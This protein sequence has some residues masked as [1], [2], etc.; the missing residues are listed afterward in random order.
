L[1]GGTETPSN[2]STVRRN[3]GAGV[4][5]P[6]QDEW[7]KAAYYDAS[8][9]TYYDYPTESDTPPDCTSPKATPNSANCGNSTIRGVTVVGA[10]TGSPSPYGTFDQGGNVSESNENIVFGGG[11]ANRGGGWT[12]LTTPLKASSV[13]SFTPTSASDARGFRLVLLGPRGGGSMDITEIGVF[14]LIDRVDGTPIVNPYLFEACVAG[15]GITSATVSPPSA[16]PIPLVLDPSGEYCFE[17]PFADSAAL[18]LAFPNGMYAFDI[19]GTGTSD[20]K[21]LDLQASEPGGYLEILNPFNGAA[22]SDEQDLNYIW[23]LVE[24]SNGAGCIVGTSCGDG[25]FVEIE[26]IGGMISTTIVDEL[27]PITA[28]GLLIPAADLFPDH[29]Y[30]AAIET[31]TGS[32][33]FGDMTDMGDPTMTVAIYEDI[34]QVFFTTGVPE[35]AAG[36]LSIAALLTVALVSRG[37]V[38]KI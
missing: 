4:V 34:N 32:P 21:T 20:S 12:G 36:L 18:D 22:V 29:L 5:L 14:K 38:G 31:F 11:R 17:Q 27:F 19:V 3:P 26:E 7:F 16:A 9:D 6:T 28:T 8:I 30:D 23:V 37:R 24:K 2:G 13:G 33:N 35:P 25:I 1:L 10:Y 15:I